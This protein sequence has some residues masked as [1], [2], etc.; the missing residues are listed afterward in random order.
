MYRSSEFIQRKL[1]FRLM[2]FIYSLCMHLWM[3]CSWMFYSFCQCYV[4]IISCWMF[5]IWE[6]RVMKWVSIVSLFEQEFL[7]GVQLNCPQGV[8]RQGVHRCVSESSG[9]K[10]FVLIPT[11]CA[12]RHRSHARSVQAEWSLRVVDLSEVLRDCCCRGA[13]GRRKFN[14]WRCLKVAARSVCKSLL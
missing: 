8:H 13:Q 1:W 7:Q 5:E 3:L 12:V 10:V 4:W 11:K 6:E 2:V 9:E 14:T